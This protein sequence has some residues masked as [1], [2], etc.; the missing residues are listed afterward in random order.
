MN[1]GTASQAGVASSKRSRKEAR[2]QRHRL[3]R[4]SVQRLLLFIV[5]VANYLKKTIN[6]NNILI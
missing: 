6:V 3:T 4:R 2:K 1:G 5:V